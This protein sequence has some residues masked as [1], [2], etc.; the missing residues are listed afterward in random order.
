[1][2][3]FCLSSVD[4]EMASM[5]VYG[6]GRLVVFNSGSDLL[7]FSSEALSSAFRYCHRT[8]LPFGVL[9]RKNERSVIFPLPPNDLSVQGLMFVMIFVIIRTD[10]YCQLAMVNIF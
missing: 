9:T 4:L 3:I 6:L 2:F 7:S 5:G 1:M 10:L 8:K